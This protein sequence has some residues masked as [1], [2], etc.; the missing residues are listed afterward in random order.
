[1]PEVNPIPGKPEIPHTV[2]RF[3]LRPFSPQKQ[4]FSFIPARPAS[5]FCGGCIVP[6][7]I[8]LFLLDFMTF[9]RKKTL[10][11]THKNLLYK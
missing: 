11:M 9:F 2:S 1:L 7:F 10:Q 4:R 8:R 5:S 3:L 6:Q